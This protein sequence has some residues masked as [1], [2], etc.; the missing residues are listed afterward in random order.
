MPEGAVITW[1]LASE[2]ATVGDARLGIE[3][4][5]RCRSWSGRGLR[6]DTPVDAFP[7]LGDLPLGDDNFARR[8]QA[9]VDE[10]MTNEAFARCRAQGTI[11]AIAP[12]AEP[13]SS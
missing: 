10:L 7:M 8:F 13:T 12:E 3:V 11:T 1:W 4:V 2:D 9:E 6:V 5:F